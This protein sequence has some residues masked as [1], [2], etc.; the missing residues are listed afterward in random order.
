MSDTPEMVERVAR[1]LYQ[2]RCR[3]MHE[4]ARFCNDPDPPKVEEWA[5]DSHGE[6]MRDEY[7]RRARLAIEAMREP[8]EA[9]LEAG[10]AV[11]NRHVPADYFIVYTPED[12]AGEIGQAMIDAALTRAEDTPQNT[13]RNP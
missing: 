5:T 13:V 6:S 4:L 9:M 1:A 2:D 3:F 11:F 10:A 8:T 7:R 12:I